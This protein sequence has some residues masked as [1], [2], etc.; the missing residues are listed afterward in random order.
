MFTRTAVVLPYGQTS[1]EITRGAPE[2]CPTEMNPLPS[3]T[4]H[5]PFIGV[6]SGI[7]QP[8]DCGRARDP[9]ALA[10]APTRP[11]PS[12]V[13]GTGYGE[14]GVRGRTGGPRRSSI[15]EHWKRLTGWI[16][17]IGNSGTRFGSAAL[18]NC[19]HQQLPHDLRVRK[20]AAPLNP[21]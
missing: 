9:A 1:T 8:L 3:R 5:P 21:W 11:A 20:S 7:G 13:K 6:E 4:I 2:P 12:P 16:G 10:G 19:R 17:W 18:N 15:S 14:H